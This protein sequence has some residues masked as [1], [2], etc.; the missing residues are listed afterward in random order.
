[1]WQT[2]AF[3]ASEE[4][5]NKRSGKPLP[6]RK[7]R[8]QDWQQWQ[9]NKNDE[10]YKLLLSSRRQHKKKVTVTVPIEQKEDQEGGE[11]ATTSVSASPVLQ[12]WFNSIERSAQ[13]AV[14]MLVEEALTASLV[15]LAQAH[16]ER[17]RYLDAEQAFDEWTLPPTE[18]ILRIPNGGSTWLPSA[19]KPITSGKKTPQAIRVD[20]VDNWC[21][22]RGLDHDEI[23]N[24]MD[25][26]SRLLP[27]PPSAL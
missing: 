10:T 20:I 23:R 26:F 7:Y 1:M 6:Y 5:A 21:K 24:N 4:P 12:N 22:A 27:C 17:C 19:T 11:T 18:A 14:G 13:V 15:P 8:P 3:R 9:Y 16:V 25:V 2:R